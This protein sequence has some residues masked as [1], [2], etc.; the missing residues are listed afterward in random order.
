MAVFLLGAK[1]GLTL[2]SFDLGAG[3]RR[4]KRGRSERRR[5]LERKWG[6]PETHPTG[7]FQRRWGSLAAPVSR[8]GVGCARFTP[9]A[10]QSASWRTVTHTVRA[11]AP[12][13]VL[14]Y[15]VGIRF[16]AGRLRRV[17]A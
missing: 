14:A 4:S 15:G 9:D 1:V 10:C 6:S 13:R 12:A 2:A 8:L 17:G 16:R 11:R 5:A 3:S 7:T